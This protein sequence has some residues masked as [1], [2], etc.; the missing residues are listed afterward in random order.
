MYIIEMKASFDVGL[1]EGW[2]CPSILVY[3]FQKCLT[4]PNIAYIVS[5][6]HNV[7]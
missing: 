3:T 5:K 4:C 2:Y 1:P 7:C 6:Y